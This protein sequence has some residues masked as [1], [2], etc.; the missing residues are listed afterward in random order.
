M[1]SFSFLQVVQQQ[2][3]VPLLMQGVIKY[4]ITNE[5]LWFY[6]DLILLVVYKVLF[7]WDTWSKTSSSALAVTSC[8]N[9][10]CC[11]GCV[12][13][14]VY[15]LVCVCV[16]EKT[17]GRGLFSHV[18]TWMKILCEYS[19]KPVTACLIIFGCCR[20][21]HCLALPSSACL[22]GGQRRAA[23]W[24]CVY[25][26]LVSINLTTDSWIYLW[27]VFKNTHRSVAM[28]NMLPLLQLS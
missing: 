11:S 24:G 15:K 8:V 2:T 28:V 18:E 9:T 21:C 16:W 1:F 25:P 26:G 6:V 22:S 10:E 7:L 4:T 12:W 14:F 13:V 20:P 23:I 5:E 19:K 3:Q 17:G 27:D